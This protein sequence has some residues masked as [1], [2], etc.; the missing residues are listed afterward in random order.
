VL[1]SFAHNHSPGAV[2]GPMRALVSAV[3]GRWPGTP[4]S[5]VILQNP[6]LGAT[7]AK[8]AH[9]VAELTLWAAGTGLPTIDVYGA[10]EVHADEASLFKDFRHPSPAGSALWAAVVEEAITPAA[11]SR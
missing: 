7:A 4:A 3:D 10:F 9:V 6:Q 2:V 5:A 1:Y 8:H 11:R